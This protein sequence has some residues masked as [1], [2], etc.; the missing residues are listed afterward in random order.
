MSEQIRCPNCHCPHC[1][2]VESRRAGSV[3]IRYRVCRFCLKRFRTRLT[4]RMDGEVGQP[5][6]Q[7]AAPTATPPKQ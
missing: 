2:T 1:P 5:T 7:A 4:E 3:L 6:E